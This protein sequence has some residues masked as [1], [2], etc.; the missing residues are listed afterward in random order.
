M[1]PG[2][3]QIS[4]KTGDAVINGVTAGSGPPLLLMHGWP[5]SLL[6]W[7]HIAPR[8]AEHFT[9]V[10]TDLR[11]YGESSKPADTENNLAYCK[12]TMA[13]DQVAVMKHLGFE[14][15]RV[16]GHDRGGRVAHRMV[17]DHP[18]RVLRLAVIDIVPT[19]T[20]YSTVNKQ[21]ATAYYHWFFLIQP[22][23]F[24]ETLL[25][26][27]GE[28]M[29]RSSFRGLS[30]QAMPE[31]V[32]KEYVRY[33]NDPATLHAM[34]EDYRAAAN[35]DLEHDK[36]DID[37]KVPCPMLVLWGQNGAM[38]RMYDVLATWRDRASNVNGKPLPGG[39]WLPE[40][41]PDRIYDEL[42]SFLQAS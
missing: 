30:K 5:Q 25:A 38:H 18:E 7:H 3:K 1:F 32:F 37:K 24:P 16:V 27:K 40:E 29:L 34:C 35:V 23:P 6:E 14:R 36:A 26:G 13:A 17:L 41:I 21:L 15:F 2:F 10:A 22:A 39:H 12:R 20:V 11:G 42:K 4:I 28:F 9:V 31:E 33:F 19:L 8:L